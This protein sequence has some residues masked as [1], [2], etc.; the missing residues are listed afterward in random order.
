MSDP[1][2]E[3]AGA[4][5]P[6][7]RRPP[8]AR[9]RLRRRPG[10]GA[11]DPG[12]AGGRGRAGAGPGRGRGGRAADR[13]DAA[14]LRGSSGGRAQ[15]ARTTPWYRRKW[16]VITG[17]V[18]AGVILF[19]GGMAV[20]STFD[21]HDRDGFRD[22]H[23]QM[24]PHGGQGSGQQ[25]WGDNG[26]G[27]GMMPPMGQGQGNGQ[28]YGQGVDPATATTGT[29]RRPGRSGLRPAAAGAE[30]GPVRGP[31]DEPAVVRLPVRRRA[32]A[33][34]RLRRGRPARAPMLRC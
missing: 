4:T 27:N 34:I 22:F 14:G 16:A 12:D 10:L 15:P 8:R 25:G 17:S 28:G 3:N 26:G 11:A 24:R 30:R 1:T 7:T 6:E 18:A 31:Y 2:N 23:G 29:G 9:P 19:L 5:P 20:G 32:A 13:G 21:G 33:P